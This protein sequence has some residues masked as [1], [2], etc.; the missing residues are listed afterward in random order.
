MPRNGNNNLCPLTDQIVAYIYGEIG[1]KAESDFEVH[2]ADCAA[3]TDEF[4]A[5]SDARFSVYEWKK[6]AFDPLPTPEIVIP[7][8][9]SVAEPWPPAKWIAA[10]KGW[11]ESLS[12]PVAVAAG[13]AVCLGIGILAFSY[14]SKGEVHVANVT[15]PA[16][17]EPLPGVVQPPEAPKLNEPV[18]TFR[19]VK[20]SSTQRS[21][22]HGP[23]DRSKPASFATPNRLTEAQN[24]PALT[25]DQETDDNS[26]RLA[27]L[28]EEVGG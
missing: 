14:L 24:A 17:K 27:D 28:F 2:L 1:G 3:C 22:K 7:Y 8:Q 11:A 21:T 15:V 19:P 10:V 13:L 16:E 5:V 4:A 9:V 12:M 6:E 26:L 25:P 23:R 20:A 18:S